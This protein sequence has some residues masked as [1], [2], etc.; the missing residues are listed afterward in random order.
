MAEFYHQKAGNREQ[1]HKILKDVIKT[2]LT[3]FPE[4][5]VENLLYQKRAQ[6]LLSRE[7]LLFE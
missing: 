4:V 6:Y 7:P 5:M 1:F 3:E 2:E